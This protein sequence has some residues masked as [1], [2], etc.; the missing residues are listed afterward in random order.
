MSQLKQDLQNK[1]IKI[2]EITSTRMSNF[3]IIGK[4]ITKT[5]KKNITT[6][7]AIIFSLKS[8]MK[9]KTKSRW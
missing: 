4:V 2:N 5:E 9:I 6:K 8:K 3:Q 1:I 7:Q